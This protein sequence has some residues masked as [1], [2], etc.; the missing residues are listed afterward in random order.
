MNS[1]PLKS[2]TKRTYYPVFL[3]ISG[4]E[5]LVVGAGSVALRKIAALLQAQARVIVVSPD[6]SA[7]LLQLVDEKKVTLYRRSYENDD[8][9]GAALVFACTNDHGVND[10]VRQDA[11]KR[12]IPVNVIDNPAACDFIVPSTVRKGDIT[13]AMSTSGDLPLL[14]RKLREKIEEVVTDDYVDYLRIIGSFRK[15]LIRT[16]TEEKKRRDIMKKIDA[17]EISDVLSK[18][19]SGIRN[20]FG[21]ESL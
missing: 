2:D 17:M 11:V 15:E 10:M 19:L 5:C 16:V 3:D 7:D 1:R 12:G 18:G 21:L 6:V 8:T 14:S 20:A 13:I 9:Q 4:K